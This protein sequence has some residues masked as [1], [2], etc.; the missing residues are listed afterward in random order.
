MDQ[1]DTLEMSV[2]YDGDT[3]ETDCLTCEQP[4]HVTVHVDYRYTTRTLQ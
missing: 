4:M 1:Q 2:Q 3:T